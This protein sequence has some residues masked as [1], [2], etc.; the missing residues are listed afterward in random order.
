M[1]DHNETLANFM[2]I[3]D[4]T[5][6]AQAFGILTASDWKLEEAV[7]LFFAS[8]A[9]G[10]S[11]GGSGAPPKPAV[12]D[13]EVQER[14]PMPAIVDRLV[15]HPM[16]FGGRGYASA[17]GLASSSRAQPAVDAFGDF[18]AAATNR[19][20]NPPRSAALSS[21][22]QAPTGLLF[23]G[24]FEGA[25]AHAAQ[26]GKWL[27]LNVQD[28]SE[29]ASHRLNRDT[30]SNGVL[31][32]MVK[33]MFVFLQAQAEEEDGVHLVSSYRLRGVPAICIIDPITGTKLFERQ[34][35]VDAEQ[36]IEDL[37]PFMDVGPKDPGAGRLAQVMAVKSRQQPAKQQQRGSEA[38]AHGRHLTEDE[39]VAMAVAASMEQGTNHAQPSSS[40]PEDSGDDE[41]LDEAAVYAAIE[42][43]NQHR[44]L[45]EQQRAEE[46]ARPPPEKVM[47]DAE[48]RLPAEPATTDSN[49]CRIAVRLPTGD[50][51]Q[52]RFLKTDSV[53]ALMDLV[54]SKVPEAA[55]GRK[56]DVVASFP[57]ALPLTEMSAS[58]ESAGVANSMLV[59]KWKD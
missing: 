7:N 14:A 23:R 42:R 17:R 15:D 4:C 51:A 13:E 3:T 59:V 48:A 40:P 47:Q 38:G 41:E 36:L 28:K 30:W 12:E 18:E 25:K 29:F 32:D 8:N 24:D 39:Q 22:F 49:A 58:L 26:E 46:L 31:R 52:R 50:R 55:G 5:D 54:L 21:L 27:M 6:D 11:G 43:E 10:G 33:G 44:A 37:V 57:G 16:Q 45:Q 56:F 53:Q 35:F 9:G 1:A 34:G 20:G 19:P 2:A